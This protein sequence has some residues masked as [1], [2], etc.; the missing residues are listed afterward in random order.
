MMSSKPVSTS[1][2]RSSQ[3]IPPA[4]TQ[5]TFAFRICDAKVFVVIKHDSLLIFAT[6]SDAYTDLQSISLSS[7]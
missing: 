2:L 4:P 5:S 7:T 1:V 6:R 3:P